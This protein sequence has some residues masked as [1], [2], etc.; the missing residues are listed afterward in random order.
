MDSL[1]LDINNYSLRELLELYGMNM[2]F[3]EDDLKQAYKTTLMT[4]PD[5]SKLDKKYFLFFSKAFK[6]IKHV[7]DMTHKEESC[8]HVKNYNVIKEHY[9]IVREKQ[10]KLKDILEKHQSKSEF[11]KWFNEMFESVH[12]SQH[13]SEG[14]GYGDWLKSNDGMHSTDNIHNIRDMH[15]YMESEKKKASALIVHKE[16]QEL[17]SNISTNNSNLVDKAPESYESGLFS[18]LQFND[19][20]K[21]HN[22]SLIPVCEDDFRR[23]PQYNSISH[24]EQERSKNMSVPSQQEAQQIYNQQKERENQQNLHNAFELSRQMEKHKD[25]EKKWWGKVLHLTN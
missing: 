5:K 20:K 16:Y 8:S 3:T 9:Q 1:D 15:S 25:I 13:E 6:L 10:D 2:D 24:L 14:T 4:H 17:N 21:A 18:K 12:D 19:V 22:E 7:Y 23:R 11:N